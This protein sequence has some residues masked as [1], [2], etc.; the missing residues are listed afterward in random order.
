[1][2]VT[3]ALEG[4]PEFVGAAATRP[5]RPVAAIGIRMLI[6]VVMMVIMGE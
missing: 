1:M 3:V 2:V 5:R 6:L 4:V